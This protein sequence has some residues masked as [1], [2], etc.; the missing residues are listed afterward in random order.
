MTWYQSADGSRWSDGE[1]EEEPGGVRL[2]P[3]MRAAVRKLKALIEGVE[4]GTVPTTPI[5]EIA[6]KRPVNQERVDEH[7][8]WMRAEMYAHG[9][10]RDAY[11]GEW[12]DLP[13]PR[14]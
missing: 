9:G 3:Q 13:L 8:T 14:G 5:E 10:G 2:T 1:D 12:D 4:A 11:G 7:L 6:A